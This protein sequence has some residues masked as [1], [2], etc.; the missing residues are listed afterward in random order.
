MLK[1]LLKFLETK[2]PSKKEMS[3][4]E[5][6]KYL[7]ENKGKGIFSFSFVR[8]E[9]DVNSPVEEVIITDDY[10]GFVFITP[11]QLQILNKQM[12]ME[13]NKRFYGGVKC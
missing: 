8:E 13:L 4:D 7:K 5:L 1:R 11:F 9:P 3:D 10:G 12:T 6:I 2:I